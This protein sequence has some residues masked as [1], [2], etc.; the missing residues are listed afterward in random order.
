MRTT[1]D[2][3]S[4]GVATKGHER[5]GFNGIAIDLPGGFVDPN[6]SDRALG[7]DWRNLEISESLTRPSSRI[8]MISDDFL[9]A[10]TGVG[11]HIQTVS[12]EL[13]RRGH[14]VSV[15]TT[16]RP[17]QPAHEVWNGV[18]IYRMF[19][20]K[21]CGYWQAL[22]RTA[23]L[24]SLFR[25]I[26][27]EIIHYH[28]LGFLLKKCRQLSKEFNALNVYTYH[29]TA[30]H[31]TQPLFMKPFRG[32]IAR[33]IVRF[34]NSC[35]LVLA[36][37]RKLAEQIPLD[38]VRT[39][40]AYVSNPIEC[41]AADCAAMSVE[42]RGFTVLY[43]GR[44]APEKNIPYLLT[45]FAAFAAENSDS[46]LHIIGDGG[47][48]GRLK[49]LTLR[50]GIDSRVRFL[51]HMDHAR[52]AQHYATADVFVLPS[53]VETQ[54]MVA[55]EAMSLGLPVL[56]SER[57]VSAHELVDDGSNGFLLDTGRPEDLAGRL[58]QL[59]ADPE[60]RAR[61]GAAGRRK[62]A[63]FSPGNVVRELET[64]Y[65]GLAD[66]RS[67]RTRS[68]FMK[69]RGAP[70]PA[71]VAGHALLS[72]DGCGGDCIAGLAEQACVHS[73]VRMWRHCDTTVWRC[74]HCGSLHQLEAVDLAPFYENYP[75]KKRRLD[76]F[77]RR[78]FAT[79]LRL[80][81]RHGMR[82]QGRILDYGC[83]SGMFLRYLHER[84][85]ENCAGYDPWV[86][87]YSDRRVL[88][89]RYDAIMA[90]DSLEH[91]EDPAGFMAEMA[92][93]LL[94]GGLM[95][96]A[97]PRAEGISLDHLQ[98]YIHALHQPYHTHILSE[99]ALI[100]LGAR[101]GLRLERVITRSML[102]TLVPFV[103]WNFLRAY[104]EARDG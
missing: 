65:R 33:D 59:S 70:G 35:N 100:A 27:P 50:L 29:M 14:R 54:G 28:Y 22:P 46:E 24:R 91:V 16:R 104:L 42:K 80:L 19:S 69:S 84:G 31:L 5:V 36:P 2:N 53:L 90:L 94:P 79:C 23:T 25:E 74:P 47:E 76:W 83:G 6:Q 56:V 101:V 72:C 57:I 95:Y 62:A 37:S 3:M 102:D 38:G 11:I 87:E 43:V 48:L 68:A 88:R 61:L 55:M 17:G 21:V 7:D 15:I 89:E 58:A 45:A 67:V 51:G 1:T 66:A 64:H 99:K 75:F 32:L 26:Q 44:L 81:L 96:V 85:F 30:D 18:H 4:D 103:N 41:N 73:N 92:G 13:A 8:C 39:P 77:A 20:V 97:T 86:A 10:A 82:K 98:P 49:N 12:A 71:T 93:L 60:L 40:V 52:L 34:C 78:V 63:A 9:P